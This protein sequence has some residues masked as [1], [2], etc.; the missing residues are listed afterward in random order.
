MELDLSDV[1]ADMVVPVT[2]IRRAPSTRSPGGR[3]TKG[4]E[5]SSPVMMVVQPLSARQAS[6]LPEGIREAARFS[7]WSRADLQTVNRHADTVPDVIVYQG[8]R[9][10]VF[11]LED[12]RVGRFVELVLVDETAA[13]G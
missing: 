6:Y 9:L 7:G 11:S 1:I 3:V 13:K 12:W 2:R 10:V 5:T 4:E 8:H